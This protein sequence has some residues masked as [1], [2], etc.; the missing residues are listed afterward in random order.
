MWCWGVEMSPE[1]GG[2]DLVELKCSKTMSSQ[3]QFKKRN[4]CGSFF[5]SDLI[6]KRD[7]IIV[8]I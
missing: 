4:D 6:L 5:M 7:R 3:R 1:E 8:I 2:L